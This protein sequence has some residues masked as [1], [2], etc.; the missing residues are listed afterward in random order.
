[1]RII[2]GGREGERA[3]ECGRE[4]GI[5]RVF[6]EENLLKPEVEKRSG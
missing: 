2:E 3:R 6:K 4:G 1:M 5:E